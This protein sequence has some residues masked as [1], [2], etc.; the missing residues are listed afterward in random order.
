MRVDD[1]LKM[2][3]QQ[4]MGEASQGDTSIS[5]YRKMGL[6]YRHFFSTVV[7][8]GIYA[9]SK[10][11]HF[12]RV[13]SHLPVAAWLFASRPA[14]LTYRFL[15]LKTPQRIGQWSFA[16]YLLQ[17]PFFSYWTAMEIHSWTSFLRAIEKLNIFKG[18][19]T[20]FETTKVTRNTDIIVVAFVIMLIGL[21]A[22][23]TSTWKPTTTWMQS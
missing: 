16:M 13:H 10:L 1:A 6:T 21:S 12:Q 2:E 11:A 4:K 23:C 19:R 15:T 3:E 7:F 20:V 17:F 9:D 22:S 8:S 18:G 14:N 5:S